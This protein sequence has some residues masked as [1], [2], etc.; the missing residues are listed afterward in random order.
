MKVNLRGH[1]VLSESA[2]E[3]AHLC[4]VAHLF[5]DDVQVA[6][7]LYVLL[8]S[9]SGTPRWCRSKDGTTVF[10]AYMGC[11]APIWSRCSLPL[12]VLNTQHTYAERSEPL[13]M[14]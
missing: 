14:R 6:P 10:H 4:E 5:T 3:A 12:H 2:L 13:L 11:E 8:F 9:G 1:M 7:G